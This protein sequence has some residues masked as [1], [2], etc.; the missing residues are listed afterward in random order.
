LRTSRPRLLR[1]IGPEIECRGEVSGR[2]Q[3]MIHR[4]HVKEQHIPKTFALETGDRN[5]L[6]VVAILVMLAREQDE[7]VVALGKNGL[8]ASFASPRFPVFKGCF[9]H[10]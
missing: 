4:R 6:G 9:G 1:Q 3:R 8:T 7:A 5:A 10:G 2:R